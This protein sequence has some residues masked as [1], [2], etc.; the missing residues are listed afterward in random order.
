MAV[1]PNTSADTLPRVLHLAPCPYTCTL[2]KLAA[3]SVCALEW[4]HRQWASALTR[5]V[6]LRWLPPQLNKAVQNKLQ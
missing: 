3:Y 5:M 4:G 6:E 1:A 2:H